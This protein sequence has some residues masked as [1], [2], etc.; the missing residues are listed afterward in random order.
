MDLDQFIRA[1]EPGWKRLKQLL[2]AFESSAD[3][4]GG[5]ERIKE[6][7]L[8]YRQSCSDSNQA[9]SYTAHPELLGGLNELIGR[10]YRLIYSQSS[11]PSLGGTLLNFFTVD[12]PA[13]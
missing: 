5:A 7:V 9:R 1:R 4:E 10:A 8:L 3:W 12:V 2:D 11:T 6:L 13:T